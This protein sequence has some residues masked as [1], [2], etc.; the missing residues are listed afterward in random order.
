[1][2]MYRVK[3]FFLA[4][5]S[6]MSIADNEFISEYMDEF[7]IRLFHKLDEGEQKHCVR[8]AF[9]AREMC[10]GKSDVDVER[11]IKACLLHDIGKAEGKINA[12]DKGLIVLM[13]A[14][15]GSKLKKIP[16]KKINIYFN[17]GEMGYNLLKDHIK[18]DRLLFLIRN[19]NEKIK[20]NVELEVLKYCD[21]RN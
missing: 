2:I 5:F 7:E 13:S 8:T 1:M 12:I 16:S 6:K 11:V 21:D 9:M 14:I 3:Q 17:H 10:E 19:H 15:I 4:V 20:G 18:D